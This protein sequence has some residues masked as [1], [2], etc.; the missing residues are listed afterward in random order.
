MHKYIIYCLYFII[1]EVSLS[2]AYNVEDELYPPV[3]CDTLDVTYS[4]T[5]L[6]IIQQNCYDCH[7]DANVSISLIPLEGYEF[8]LVKVHDGQL[9]KAIRH[10]GD[11]TP[12]PKDRPALSECD[13]EK[14][15]TWVAHGAPNN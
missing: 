13:I 14:L 6:P 5:V 9:I 1:M 11:V 8:V 2:C 3:T 4:G 15:E 10:T 12:M 7:S